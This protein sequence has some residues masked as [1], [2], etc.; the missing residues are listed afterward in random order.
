MPESIGDRTDLLKENEGGKVELA[1]KTLKDGNRN[2]VA[3]TLT[4]IHFFS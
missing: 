1:V 2:T 4:F 3:K